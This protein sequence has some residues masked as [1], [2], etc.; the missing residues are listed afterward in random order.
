[1]IASTTVTVKCNT[2]TALY[3]LMPIANPLLNC[4]KSLF[5]APNH[6]IISLSLLTKGR[7]R[8]SIKNM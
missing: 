1:M 2:D 3:Q 5:I 7:L 8:P 6:K 4:S